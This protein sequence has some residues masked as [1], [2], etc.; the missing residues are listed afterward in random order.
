MIALYKGKSLLS[1]VIRIVNWNDYSHAAW[2]DPDDGSVIEAWI[3]AG[4]RRVASLSTQHTPGTCVDLFDVFGETPAHTERIRINL[5]ARVGRGY[6]FWG[7][8]HFVTRRPEHSLSQDKWF[9]SELVFAAY[10]QVGLP[11]LAR[12]PAWKVHPGMLSYSPLLRLRARLI[13]GTDGTMLSGPT[14]HEV[15]ND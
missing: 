1:R 9:C 3:G 4:V 11:L 14:T 6:D 12:V 2:F 7:A 15:P 5:R 10:S 13:T 8:L